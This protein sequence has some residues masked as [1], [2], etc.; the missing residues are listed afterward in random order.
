MGTEVVDI[1]ELLEAHHI[2]LLSPE[3]AEQA[4]HRTI[5]A[6]A[7]LAAHGHDLHAWLRGNGMEL[8]WR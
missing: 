4:L 2:G 7:G 1:D 6:V 5:A 8:T 3:T